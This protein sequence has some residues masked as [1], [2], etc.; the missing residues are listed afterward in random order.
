MK[1]SI[2]N[3]SPRG[4]NSNTNI[5]VNAFKEGAE[6][7]GAEV[8]NYFLIDKKINH[9]KGCFSCWRTEYSQ[10]VYNDD[11]KELID[12]YKQSDVVCYATPV[13]TWDMTACLKNF[14]D[15]L[16]PLKSF[17]V[18]EGN[19]NYDMQNKTNKNPDI[20]IISNAGFPGDNNFKT[21]KKVVAA[22]NPILEIYRNCGMLLQSKKND[23]MEMVDN[24]LNY[25]NKAGAAIGKKDNV[26]EDV[27]DGLRM[28]L[29][30]AERYLEYISG[31]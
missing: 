27:L 17:A 24:Y 12:A 28:E 22:A 25:V 31:K 26:S 20:V 11:M 13:Y 21:I 23:V 10:C 29:M 1:I 6:S 2:F 18:V 5:I 4:K 3:G 9:C 8:T 30:P 16:I 19:G 15:R 14:I 7:S